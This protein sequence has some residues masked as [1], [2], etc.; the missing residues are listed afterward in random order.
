MMV[1]GFGQTLTLTGPVS[2]QDRGDRFKSVPQES[3]GLFPWE[4]GQD[5]LAPGR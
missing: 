4:G 2:L 1:A 5:A 3:R